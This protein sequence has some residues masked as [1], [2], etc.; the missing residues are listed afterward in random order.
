M[1][2][3]GVDPGT[4]KMG[5]GVVEENPNG[6][7]CLDWGVLAP[8]KGLPLHKRLHALYLGLLEIAV[9]WGP[10]EVAVEESFVSLTRGARA[11]LVVGQAQGIVLLT[12]AGRELDVYRYAPSQ[13]KGAVADYGAA[14]KSQVQEMVRLLL[15]LG[16]VSLPNDAADALAVALCHIKQRQVYQLTTM[17][18]ELR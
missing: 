16:T 9:R 8:A 14:S 3:L 1:R 12:A 4:L 10:D 7:L 13:V 2:I 17:E 18:H 15:G 5:Y 11:A 6:P